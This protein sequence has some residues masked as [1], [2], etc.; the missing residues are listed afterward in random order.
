MDNKLDVMPLMTDQMK[1]VV[2]KQKEL[3]CVYINIINYLY[4]GLRNW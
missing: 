1:A 3:S 2:R 4:Y